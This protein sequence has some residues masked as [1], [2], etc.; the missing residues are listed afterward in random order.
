MINFS[1]LRCY[2][3]GFPVRI[4]TCVKNKEFLLNVTQNLLDNENHY[5]LEYY[6]R[7]NL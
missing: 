5:H 4:Q 1:G 2:L 7:I 6:I 3:Y